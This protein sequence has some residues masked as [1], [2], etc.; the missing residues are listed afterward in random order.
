M[1]VKAKSVKTGRLNNCDIFE[2]SVCVCVCVCVYVG[3]VCTRVYI[4]LYP[5]NKNQHD[6]VYVFSLFQ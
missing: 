1:N 5:C 2:G 4:S 3:S 6:A